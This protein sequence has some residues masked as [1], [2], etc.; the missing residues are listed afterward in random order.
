MAR[1]TNLAEQ[2]RK[3][4][5]ALEEHTRQHA[6]ALEEDIVAPNLAAESGDAAQHQLPYVIGKIA[7][8]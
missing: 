2:A 7:E 4:A 5:L 1:E 3:H 8:V 6:L